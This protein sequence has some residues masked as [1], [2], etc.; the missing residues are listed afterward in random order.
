MAAGLPCA[1]HELVLLALAS[2]P[3]VAIILL[4]AAVKLH[5]LHALLPD[6]GRLRHEVLYKMAADGGERRDS[7]LT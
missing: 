3:P 4:V 1:H 5:E 6:V 2:R 7:G